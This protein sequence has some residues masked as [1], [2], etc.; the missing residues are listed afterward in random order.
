MYLYGS[1]MA[2]GFEPTT[3][4]LDVLVVTASSID[5]LDL[6]I[7][8]GLIDRLMAREPEWS[9]RLDIAFVDRQTV[10]TFRDGGPLL[11]ISHDEPLR[12]WDSAADWLQT[13][14]L[15]R[16]ADTAVLGPP[17]SEL[18]P[19]I[20]T[21]EFIRTVVDGA[22]GLIER[23]SADRRAGLRAYLVLSLGR[24]LRTLETGVPC[25]KIEGAAR[26]IGAHPESRWIV[27]EC[28]AIWRARGRTPFSPEAEVALEGLA[29][30]LG[31]EIRARRRTS[32]S[33]FERVEPATD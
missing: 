6:A 18:I 32:A 23:L 12:R 19:A 10:V 14:Y 17:P 3:S 5:A 15:V 20:E 13:W 7:F 27:D 1:A 8:G 9:D 29:E 21:D 25:S 33:T 26:I 28:L 24:I 31:S 22:D 16:S 30:R 2:G 4:D 11:S